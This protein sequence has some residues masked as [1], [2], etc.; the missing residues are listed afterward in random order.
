MKFFLLLFLMFS[1]PSLS[2]VR[3]VYQSQNKT[4]VLAMLKVLEA[5]SNLTT[6]EQCY[7]AVFLCMKADYLT[8]PNEKLAAFKKGY[9]DLNTLVNSN[10]Q[11]A[12][13]RYHRYM[14][15]KHTPSWLIEQS[16]M[17]ED[18]AYVLAN[19]KASHPMSAFIRK[20]I[21]K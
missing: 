2:D 15:E 19:L 16:H 1:S 4:K 21:E 20:T 3:A 13:Y 10:P 6:D 12:E 18:R 8:W 14:I 7:K 5:K 9:G 17:K 11:N